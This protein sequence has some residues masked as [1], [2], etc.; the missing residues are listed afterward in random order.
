MG[1]KVWGKEFMHVKARKQRGCTIIQM[2]SKDICNHFWY[3][4]KTADTYEDFFDR[5]AGLLHH[6]TGEHVWALGAC[7]HG[8][9]VED[10][11]KEWIQKGSVA[12]QRLT[13][14]VLD[15]RWLKSV[16]KYLHF[17]STAE[18]E[19]FHNHILMYA[20]KH[21]CFSPPMYAARV[22]LAGL[23]Y[24]HNVDRPAKRRADGSIQ[25]DKVHNKK[26]RKWSLYTLKVEKDYSYIVDLESAILRRRLSV[27][28]GLPRTARKRPDNTLQHGVLSGVPAPSTQEL[29]QS[30]LSRGLG[31][32]LPKN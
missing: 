11:E 25:Y 19:S 9:L 32:S 12:H 4:C 2:W 10:R 16:H 20:S 3:C 15:A 24:N 1:P 18:L 28:G 27:T 13:E 26:S 22:M 30:Q 21:F 17:R 31:K 7:Q 8:P 5:W 6:V 23:D 14:V 29:L